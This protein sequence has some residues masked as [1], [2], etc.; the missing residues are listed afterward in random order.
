MTLN[1]RPRI[2]IIGT[3]SRIDSIDNSL[4]RPGRFDKE[5]EFQIPGPL[6]RAEIIK[7]LLNSTNHS[8]NDVEIENIASMAHGYVGSDLNA[9]V[10][11]AAIECLHRNMKS[12]NI[13][14]ESINF[15]ELTIEYMDMKNG[16]AKVKPSSIREVVVQVPNVKWSD[17]GGQESIKQRLQEAISLPLLVQFSNSETRV[18]QKIQNQTTKRIATLRPSWM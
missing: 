9:I 16:M 2:V 4:R 10:K 3:T 7:T 13:D 6:Q 15:L 8:L 5:I 1:Q 17:I 18:I 14:L 12:A 11:E